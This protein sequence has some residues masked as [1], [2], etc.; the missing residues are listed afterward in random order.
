MPCASFFSGAPA[1]YWKAKAKMSSFLLSLFSAYHSLNHFFFSA[2][3]AHGS[4]MSR[5]QSVVDT[6]EAVE[7]GSWNVRAGPVSV[8]VRAPS[9]ST[10][11]ICPSDPRSTDRAGFSSRDQVSFPVSAEAPE[12]LPPSRTPTLRTSVTPGSSCLRSST[13]R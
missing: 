4:G 10:A 13:V 1:T 9:V 12:P 2:P 3:A 7:V 5:T 11:L 6:L 8:A